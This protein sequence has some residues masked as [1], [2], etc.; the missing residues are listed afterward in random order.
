MRPCGEAPYRASQ[1]TEEV[2]GEC[3]SLYYHFHRK[4]WVSCSGWGQDGLVSPF[5]QAL[6]PKDCPSLSRAWPCSDSGRRIGTL[7]L[8]AQ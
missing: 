8:R 2:R 1:E 7:T 6:R 5:Q 4:E 3:G